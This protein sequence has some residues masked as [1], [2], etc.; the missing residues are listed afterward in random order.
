MSALTKTLFALTITSGLALS[1][2]L[3]SPAEAEACGCFVPPDPTVPIV[4]AGERILFGQENGVITAHIQVQYSGPAEEFG[5]LLPMPAIPEMELGSDELFDVMLP[6]PDVAVSH[7]A[8][9]K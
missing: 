5:W 3:Q 6:R 8:E 9:P 2:H 4:Q 1:V 7:F